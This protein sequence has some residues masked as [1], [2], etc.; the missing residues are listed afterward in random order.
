[1]Q[2]FTYTEVSIDPSC[3][4]NFIY[5]K[6]GAFIP[7]DPKGVIVITPGSNDDGRRWINDDAWK[8]FALTHQFALMGCY[9][10]DRKPSWVEQYI[11]VSEG[12]GDAFIS[13]LDKLDLE[14]LPLYLYGF[15]AGGE[16]NYE[17]ACWLAPNNPDLIKAFVVN[18]GGVYYSM[19]APE[20]TRKIP[21]LFFTGAHDH[22]WRRAVVHGIFALNQVAG[23]SWVEHEEML[24]HNIGQSEDLSR[25]LFEII[26]TGGK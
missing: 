19:L 12:S 3:T 5:A 14:G 18:K 2:E 8:A 17:L 25:E 20:E 13:A 4:D 21:A 1:M 15:S 22:E 26:I 16:F 10:Q 6:F 9:F 7:P 24:G 23:A 11:Q